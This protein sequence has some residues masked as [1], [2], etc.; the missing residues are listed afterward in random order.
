MRCRVCGQENGKLC[1]NCAQ[2]AYCSKICQRQDWKKHKPYCSKEP[3]LSVDATLIAGR[4]QVSDDT[5]QRVI[6]RDFIRQ[7]V[8]RQGLDMERFTCGPVS[9]SA[10]GVKALMETLFYKKLASQVDLTT[11]QVLALAQQHSAHPDSIR[12]LAKELYARYRAGHP[13]TIVISIALEAPEEKVESVENAIHNITVEHPES[14]RNRAKGR[15]RLSCMENFLTADIN[16]YVYKTQPDSTTMTINIQSFAR[17][18][19]DT[20]LDSIEAI[21][22][23]NYVFDSTWFRK[24]APE[25]CGFM[26]EKVLHSVCCLGATYLEMFFDT[27]ARFARLLL[28]FKSENR[29]MAAVPPMKPGCV[30]KLLGSSLAKMEIASR[31]VHGFPDECGG[32]NIRGKVLVSCPE[33]SEPRACSPL[34]LRVDWN[35]GHMHTCA[36]NHSENRVD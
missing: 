23:S 19:L 1:T 14:A 31:V 29:V 9:T 16:N 10:A 12:T 30:F 5:T 26:S 28:N 2:V 6:E 35:R 34:C 7:V 13:F 27:H 24:L 17:P 15:K 33:C 36:A 32:C 8:D 18:Y 25:F 4:G 3:N 20:S 22:M 11:V 21:L